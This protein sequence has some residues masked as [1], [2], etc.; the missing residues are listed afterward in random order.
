MRRHLE[1]HSSEKANKCNQCDFASTSAS[2][3]SQHFKKHV[4]EKINKCD[5][6]GFASTAKEALK[7]HLKIQWRKIK[8]MQ[9]M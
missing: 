1:T 8:Q 3:L 7:I 2:N 6:C 9:S 5:L 4:G